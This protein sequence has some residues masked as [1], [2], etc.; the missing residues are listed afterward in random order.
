MAKQH[1][2]Q[3]R[4]LTQALMISGLL[5]VAFGG[6]LV[7]WMYLEVPPT[8]YCVLK[9]TERLQGHTPLAAH[10]SISE[11][12]KHFK[13]LSYPQLVTKLSSD[14]HVEDGYSERN[15]ALAALVT[16]HHFDLRS[17][18]SGYSQPSQHRTLVYDDPADR[19]PHE[20]VIY[21]GLSFQ[22]YQAIIHYADT[23]KW[24]FTA[25]G[26]FSLI[27]K[28]KE[29]DPSLCDTF[30][31]T[32]EFL[33]VE[34]LF[35]RL[36]V[37]VGRHE[38][39]KMLSEG[40]WDQLS[41][42]TEQQRAA[43]DLSQNRRRRFVLDYLKKGSVAAAEVLIKTDRDFALRQVDDRQVLALLGSEEVSSQEEVLP[44]PE[45]EKLYVVQKGDSLWKI[46]HRFEVTILALKEYNHL[47]SDTLRPNM[48]LKIPY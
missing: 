35:S 42:F 27:K 25:Q 12:V 34:L 24:P 8:P 16:F 18:L 40:D 38:L 36:N 31:Q 5:N 26:L 46:A 37:T 22:Q 2:K 17:A 13:T 4:R 15:L 28:E 43:Q 47:Q 7:Y 30:F 32:P 19:A 45:Q 29:V 48:T 1:L 6:L 23:E 3:I 41:A 14:Q 20:I 11:V 39:L 44:L 9:P 10:H 33:S 21:P